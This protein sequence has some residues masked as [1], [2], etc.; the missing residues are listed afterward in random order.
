MVT[1]GLGFIGSN[2]TKKF[3]EAGFEVVVMDNLF[4]GEERNV[5]F[6]KKTYKD[7]L[8]V[9]LGDVRDIRFLR[10]I[11]RKVDYVIHEAAVSSASM[12]DDAPQIGVEVNIIGFQNILEISRRLGNIK[13]I[14]YASTSS[15]Y[16][17]FDPPHREDLPV[18]PRTF[19]EYT[20]FAREHLARIYYENYGVKII[21]MRY[22]SIYGPNE[23]HKLRYANIIT[24]FLWLMLKK[25][26]PKIYGDGNQ[27]RDF[28]YVS[29]VA[30]ATLLAIENDDV[31]FGIL[32]VGTGIET[33]FNDVVR[34]L[35]DELGTDIQPIYME[36]PIKKYVYR[37][38]ADT[39]KIKKILG[40]KPKIK[41]RQGIKY[42]IDFYK[43]IIN[44]IPEEW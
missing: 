40:F 10:E 38:Q 11:L 37:T 39:S 29:D 3:L 24:Q 27:T 9:V 42:Q 12:F 28:T 34:M 44:Q 22:F 18:Y 23:Q 32:N 7:K 30:E 2:I 14:I 16:G 41:V 13:K 8:K 43:P 17:A 35:N 19:Y 26:R 5:F 25:K 6:L 1:G 15:L 21:G 31:E 36:N 20:M 33:T 4:L